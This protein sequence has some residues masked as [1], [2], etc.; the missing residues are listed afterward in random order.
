MELD[1]GLMFGVV[2]KLIS[3][4]FGAYE[5]RKRTP[6]AIWTSILV[7]VATE[8]RGGLKLIWIG[9]LTWLVHSCRSFSSAYLYPS[10]S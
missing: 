9:S 7:W 2:G 3:L 5:R 4:A 1:M 6:Y 10:T 8:V